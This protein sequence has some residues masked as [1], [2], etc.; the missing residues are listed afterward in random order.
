MKSWT[1]YIASLRNHPSIF[2]WTLLNEMYMGANFTRGGETFGAERF[3]QIKQEL[4]PS[5]L[6]MDQDGACG[7]QD[8]RDSLSFC[9]AHMH[10]L[11][12]GCVGYDLQRNC[13]GGT[14][15]TAWVP[16]K[17]HDSCNLT[18]GS[19]AFTPTPKIPIISHETGNYNTYP[20]ITS[21]IKEFNRSGTTIR[22]YW[23]T[24]ALDKLNASG[25]LSEVDQWAT[26]SEKLYVTCWKLDIE[27][28]R[29]NPQISG[30][31]WCVPSSQHRRLQAPHGTD[32]DQV[33]A[34]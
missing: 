3:Y 7:S 23:L 9:S 11:S 2:T 4:D 6:M 1:S 30:Y 21:L 20:R 22:P 10:V 15:P 12:M 27:D 29:H 28:H 26:A 18:T 31:E 34:I 33:V 25:L 24:G 13:L 5:R 17:Y 32:L 8:V 16:N 19:C 14:A